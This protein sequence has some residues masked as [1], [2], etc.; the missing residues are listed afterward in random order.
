M[1]QSGHRGTSQRSPT[2]SSVMSLEE[3]MSD[4]LREPH[5]AARSKVTQET[6]ATIHSLIDPAQEVGSKR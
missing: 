5:G 6:L 3:M 2:R 4:C 1:R